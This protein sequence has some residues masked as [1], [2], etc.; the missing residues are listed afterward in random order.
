[1]NRK[2]Y[3]LP[4]GENSTPGWQ[5]PTC[6]EGLLRIKKG[7]FFSEELSESKK[8]H[9]HEAWDPDWI[10]YIYSCLLQCTND[11]CKEV[12]ASSGT[13]MVYY[14]VVEDEQGYP[15]QV[16]GDY[17]K[18]K[19]FQP[20]LKLIPIPEDA[21]AEVANA[22]N[23]SFKLFFC[24]PSA[25]SNHVRAS[26]EAILTDLK[27]KRYETTKGKRRIISLHRRI[28]LLQGKHKD[29][30]DLFLA[31]KWLGNAGSHIGQ[32]LTADDV[33]DAYEI[34]EHILDEVYENKTAKVKAIAKKVN[35]RKG[36]K[37]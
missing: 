9:G 5:C 25:A 27:V 15:E 32:E 30:Y 33:M 6:N 11:K 17:F 37:K 18:P 36:P 24:S 8:A 29:L 1:M 14:D 12:V 26:V 16:W 31:V 23:E 21:P 4:F 19:H 7:T 35:K 28:S 3:K 10:E 13:G 2:L 34:M 22:L 20:H